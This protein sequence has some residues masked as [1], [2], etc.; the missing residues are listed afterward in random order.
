MADCWVLPRMVDVSRLNAICEATQKDLHRFLLEMDLPV[1]EQVHSEINDRVWPDQKW[2]GAMEKII[3]GLRSRAG[4][5]E[6]G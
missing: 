2:I 4:G 3:A 1:P 6:E 5:D